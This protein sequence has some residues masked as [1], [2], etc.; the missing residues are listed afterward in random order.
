MRT[1]KVSLIIFYDE[2]KRILMQNR[3]NMIKWGED[4]GF[5]GGEIEKGE[6]PEQ[7][8]LRETKEELDF[9]LK[10]YKYIGKTEGKIKDLLY[11]IAH[12]YVSP[13]ENK[14]K[15]F[16]QMEGKGMEFFSVGEAMQLKLAGEIDINILKKIGDYFENEN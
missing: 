12:I 15:E 16:N 7:A 5:F 8:V 3:K 11:V 4:W 1:R 13:I 9:N 6:T 14:I 10:K 2:N